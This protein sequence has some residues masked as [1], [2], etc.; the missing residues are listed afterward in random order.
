MFSSFDFRWPDGVA[1]L[2]GDDLFLVVDP[3]LSIEALSGLDPCFGESSSGFSGRDLDDE[4]VDFDGVVVGDGCF[5]SEGDDGVEVDSG[6]FSEEGMLLG[7]LAGEFFIESGEEIIFDPRVCLFGGFDVEELHFGDEAVLEGFEFVFDPS[8]GLGRMGGDGGD[9]EFLEDHSDLGG[10]LFSGDLFLQCPVVVVSVEGAVLVVVDGGGD[11]SRFDD[12]FEGSEIT[13]GG[14]G[15]FEV[16]GEDLVGG[17]IDGGEEA[18]L[19]FVFPEP[20]V[21]A[22]V[23][24]DHFAVAVLGRSSA[25]MSL[26]S[27][28]VFG[29]DAGGPLDLADGFAAEVDLL[30]F[31]E[32]FGEMGVVEVAVFVLGEF[33]DGLGGFGRGFVGRASSS[34]LVCDPGGSPDQEIGFYPFGLPI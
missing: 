11:S 3:P 26:G 12:V 7:G 9:A 18:L 8:L 17:V 14:F 15:G 10:F 33:A 31:G 4:V 16:E 34:V 5:V 6:W 24:L 2:G 20:L 1:F 27:S 30:E 13:D 19:W 23:P 25:V 21:V 22:S 29:F 32:H 28:S